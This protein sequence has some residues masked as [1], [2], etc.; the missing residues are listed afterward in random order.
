M[1]SAGR[2]NIILIPFH[3][4]HDGCDRQVHLGW[5]LL[6]KVT[7]SGLRAAVYVQDTDDGRQVST[8]VSV[9]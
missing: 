3:A 5:Y 6:P 9:T 2:Q 7:E 8:S 4:Q 1:K